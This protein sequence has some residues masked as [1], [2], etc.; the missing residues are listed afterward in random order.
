ML[1]LLLM[2]YALYNDFMRIGAFKLLK[3]GAP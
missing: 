1:L 2:V 3:W